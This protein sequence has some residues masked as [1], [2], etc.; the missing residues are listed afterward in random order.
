MMMMELKKRFSGD[1]QTGLTARR[2]QTAA[3]FDQ[4]ENRPRNATSFDH[5]EK[6]GSSKYR[7]ILLTLQTLFPRHSCHRFHQV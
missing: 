3:S 5:E 1:E 6:E 2:T 4:T 7:H